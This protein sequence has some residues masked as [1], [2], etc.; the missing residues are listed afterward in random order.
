[1]NYILFD[2]N[3]IKEYLLPL[4]YFRPV[5]YIRCGILTL[6]EKWTAQLEA[7]VQVLTQDYLQEKF[8]PFF[9]DE[10]IYINSALLPNKL[11]ISAVKNLK[12]GEQLIKN[13]EVLAF[14]TGILTWKKANEFK[15]QPV[16]FNGEYEKISR[17]YDIFSKNAVQIKQDFELITRN[18]QSQTVSPTNIIIGD[19][20]VF[21]EEG[22]VAEAVIFNTEEG[23]VYLGKNAKVLEGSM[24]RGPFAALEHAVVKMGAKIYGGTTLGPYVKA[25]GEIKDTVFFGYANKGHDGYLGDSV[26]AEWCNLGADTNNSNLK[27][28]YS[29]V[30]VW[31][32][33]ENDFVNTGLQFC[34]L[35]MGDHSKSGIA[36]MFNTGT[37]VGISSNIFGGDYQPKFFPSFK[38]GG[39]KY[40]DYRFDKAVEV[41]KAVFKRRQKDFDTIEQNLFKKVYNLVKDKE[42]GNN[43]SV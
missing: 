3:N 21:I 24:I 17:T 13:N 22:A 10:N 34:G 32:Y 26:I 4:T 11:L 14:R 12:K 27:N 6:Q 31:Q 41:A 8:P 39:Q 36:T 43:K 25:G 23:P 2:Q 7:P 29:K 19:N 37:V 33:P 5:S 9:S 20:P 40:V 30:K 15:G 1:M 28:N 35:I 38:W 18:K 42:T 16:N